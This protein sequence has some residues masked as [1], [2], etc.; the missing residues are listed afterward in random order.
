MRGCGPWCMGFPPMAA[1]FFRGPDFT[2]RGH[3]HLVGILSACPG[4]EQNTGHPHHEGDARG[5]DC[6]DVAPSSR[7][8]H[9][10]HTSDKL[11]PALP[12]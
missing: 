1:G 12:R 5:R 3:V 6:L 10:F 2:V 7:A 11:S 4:T 8:F 9:R